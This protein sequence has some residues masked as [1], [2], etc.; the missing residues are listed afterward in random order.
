MKK[1]KN[2]NT[3][4]IEIDFKNIKYD[5]RNANKIIRELRDTRKIAD[6][7]KKHIKVKTIGEQ[8]E[9]TH[10]IVDQYKYY[11]CTA[12]NAVQIDNSKER[13]NYLYDEICFYLDNVCISKN[14]CE[15]KNDK[16]FVK[17][18]TDT[19]MGCCHHYPNKKWGMLYQKKMVPCEYLGEK[20]CTTKAIGCKMFMCDEINKKGYNFTVYN[21]L[22]IKYFFNIFQKIIIKTGVF[23][24]K[25]SIMKKLLKYSF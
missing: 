7:S 5:K 25:E 9:D 18:N 6:L 24:T 22:L 4:Y 13:C 2:G 15:F 8:I 21:V 11:I 14:L 19:T 12:I 23:Q 16:C 20:G 3:I 10:K 17:R 1:Y